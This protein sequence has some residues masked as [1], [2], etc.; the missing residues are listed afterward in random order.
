MP[1]IHSLLD[2][3]LDISPLEPPRPPNLETWELSRRCEFVRRL[4]IDLEKISH[5]PHR[6]NLDWHDVSRRR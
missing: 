4:L 2:P 3:A 5:L 1:L 6:E